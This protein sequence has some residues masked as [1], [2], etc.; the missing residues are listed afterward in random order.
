MGYGSRVFLVAEDDSLRRIPFSRFERLR[1]SDLREQLPE[2]ANKRL[3]YAVA[4]VEV[5]GRKVLSV[6]E[7]TYG[8]LSFDSAGRLDP[9]YLEDEM[10]LL[11]RSIPPMLP[12][13]KPTNVIDLQDKFATRRY[14]NEFSW[15]PAPKI[16]KAIYD[17]IF[18]L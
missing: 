2:H 5:E 1:D 12:E 6:F 10:C 8:Y 3:R 4:V 13:V 9:K 7:I 11:L 18:G 17:S 14:K 16:E 15:Q